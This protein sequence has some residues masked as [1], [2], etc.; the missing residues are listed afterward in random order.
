MKTQNK[1]ETVSFLVSL[2][3]IVNVTSLNFG[4]NKCIPEE[5]KKIQI[6]K[7]MYLEEPLEN[8]VT[9]LFIAKVLGHRDEE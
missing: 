9:E 6:T 8:N 1:E 5:K 4:Q 7:K 3:V 2:R